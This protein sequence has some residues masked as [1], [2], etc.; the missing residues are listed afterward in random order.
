MRLEADAGWIAT[1]ARSL[2]PLR[3]LQPTNVADAV[4]AL[5]SSAYACVLAGGIDLVPCFNEGLMP[6]TVID[7][8]KL[9]E[10]R[11]VRLD[12]ALLRIGALVTPGGDLH[13]APADLW[14]D[15]LPSASLL[16]HIEIDTAALAAFHCE[17]SMRPL[18]TQALAAFR[19][20]EALRISF[21]I[22]TEYLAPTRVE[23]RHRRSSTA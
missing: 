8:S 10:L 4:A 3:L 23:H 14:R 13:R 7:V 17:R 19:D 6:Q 2:A 5:A 1:S 12:G 20:G 22:A 9:D 11:H 21:A 18:M 16:T 15:D